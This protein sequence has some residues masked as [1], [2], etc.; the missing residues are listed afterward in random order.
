MAF[1]IPLAMT[2]GSALLKSH[3]PKQARPIVPFEPYQV[4]AEDPALST[5]EY[6]RRLRAARALMAQ[7]GGVPTGNLEV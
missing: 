6:R 4:P 7:Y 2:L 1:W 3:Q 5:D